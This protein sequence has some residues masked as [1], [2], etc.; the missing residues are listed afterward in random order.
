VLRYLFPR[1]FG[2]FKEGGLIRAAFVFTDSGDTWARYTT[3]A[4]SY[5]QAT[6]FTVADAG[7]G[8]VTVTFP[9][10]KEVE[11]IHASIRNPTVGTVGNVR[12]IELPHMTKTVAQ[13]GTFG[14]CLYTIDGTEALADPVDQ[15][16]LAMTLYI[17]K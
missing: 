2:Q 3:D 12:A 14:L 15:A 10:C 11:V 4:H 6:D 7:T 8:L 16:V 5:G 13:A 17:G 1:L 9:K